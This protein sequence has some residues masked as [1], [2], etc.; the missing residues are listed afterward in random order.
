VATVLR[1]LLLVGIVVVL[2]MMATRPRQFRH[3]LLQA[4][5]LGLIYVLAVLISAALYLF[6]FRQ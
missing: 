1:T 5:K 6:G 3:L 2:F 4:R